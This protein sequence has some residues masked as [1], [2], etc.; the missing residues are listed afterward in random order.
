M[1]SQLFHE[2]IAIFC[3]SSLAHILLSYFSHAHTHTFFVLLPKN[4]PTHI[5]HTTTI[6][7]HYPFFFLLADASFL[8]VFFTHNQAGRPSFV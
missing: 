8:S 7:H 5:T 4:K 2:C 3:N 1:N 6:V